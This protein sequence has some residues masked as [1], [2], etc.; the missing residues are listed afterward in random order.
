MP[1]AGAVGHA[2]CNFNPPSRLHACPRPGGRH[3]LDVAFFV[4]AYSKTL[5]GAANELRAFAGTDAGRSW[6]SAWYHRL[7]DL[8]SKTIDAPTDADAERYL[9]MVLWYFVDSGPLVAPCSP[10]ISA[11]ADAMLRRRKRRFIDSRNQ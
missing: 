2:F 11:A 4:N 1:T 6:D 8:T 5:A 7:I 9:D 10:A 3:T